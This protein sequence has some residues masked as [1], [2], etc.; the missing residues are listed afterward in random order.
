MVH[1]AGN[2][3]L[4][5]HRLYP[6]WQGRHQGHPVSARVLGEA[7]PEGRAPSDPGPV[8]FGDLSQWLSSLRRVPHTGLLP[9]LEGEAEWDGEGGTMDVQ[10]GL[11]EAQ[12]SYPGG[13]VSNN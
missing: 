8:G 1:F 9:M 3:L 10:S 12:V 11:P 2:R 4:Q 6:P 5:S 7:S 13:P